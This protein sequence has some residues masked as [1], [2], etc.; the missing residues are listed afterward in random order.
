MFGSRWT[1]E[2]K[3]AYRAAF[4]IGRLVD[5]LWLVVAVAW[6]LICVLLSERLSVPLTILVTGCGVVVLGLAAY[7][8]L[9]GWLQ[10]SMPAE[11][12]E[13]VP[14]ERFAGA[15]APHAPR[16][17]RELVARWLTR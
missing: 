15:S 11:L 6:S 14:V 1:A 7:R 4:T 9:P 12:R 10:A 3:R 17:Y 13:A 2:E 16:T 8:W 5:E